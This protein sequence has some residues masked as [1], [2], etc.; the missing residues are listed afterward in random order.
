MANTNSLS[1]FYVCATQQPTVLDATGFGA[2]TWVE[3]SGV[4]D[5][6]SAGSKTNVLSYD[7][8]GDTVTQKSK[9]MTDAGSPTLEVARIPTDAGQIIMRSI[10]NTNFNYAY[11][12]ARNDPAT[13]GGTPTIIYNRGLA[14][15]PERPFGKTED[16]DLE[17]FT[18]AFNQKEVVVDPT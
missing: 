12:I 4:G 3:V 13:V 7:T 10:A 11:K 18:L 8:W 5:M 16:F 6:G 9:G 14:A 15:G 2:L 17:T 1:K